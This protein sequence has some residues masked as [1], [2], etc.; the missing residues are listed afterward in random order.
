M[1]W[2]IYASCAAELKNV[3]SVLAILAKPF[4]WHR[5]PIGDFLGNTTLFEHT[6]HHGLICQSVRTTV[7][8]NHEN[9]F[10]QKCEGKQLR[11]EE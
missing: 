1:Q 9:C 8:C 7:T 4:H 5:M 3:F 11:Q 2:A 10:E 6:E